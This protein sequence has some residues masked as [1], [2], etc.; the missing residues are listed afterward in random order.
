[1]LYSIYY[2]IKETDV[3]GHGLDHTLWRLG[4]PRGDPGG[5]KYILDS[6]S[7]EEFTRERG[8]SVRNLCRFGATVEKGLGL[9]RRDLSLHGA[10]E[11]LAIL[12]YGGND[13]DFAWAEVAAGALGRAPVQNAHGSFPPGIRGGHPALAPGGGRPVAA[14]PIPVD[15]ERYLRWI[16]RDGLSRERILEWLGDVTAI[17][18]WEEWYA[19]GGAGRGGVHGGAGNR[20]TPGF[21]VPP[22]DG[23]AFVRGRHPSHGR[24]AEADLRHLRPRTGRSGHRLRRSLQAGGARPGRQPSQTADLPGSPLCGKLSKAPAPLPSPWTAGGALR[25]SGYGPGW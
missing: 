25:L 17:Y 9:I 10:P 3:H 16:C 5:G 12:E 21:P 20:F 6:S 15:P 19:P 24:G 14:I 23:R 11:G 7:Q 2:Q 13:S 8:I 1:M 22:S 4:P 18:R